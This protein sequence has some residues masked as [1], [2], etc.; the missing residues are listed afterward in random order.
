MATELPLFVWGG[1]GEGGVDHLA[2]I[3]ITYVR[4]LL[5]L[6]GGWVFS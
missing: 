6:V 1:G 5:V 3:K 2:V 4:T